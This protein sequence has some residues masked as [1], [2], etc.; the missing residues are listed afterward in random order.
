MITS[1]D[2]ERLKLVRKLADRKH[3][4]RERL[5]AAEG[6]D[7]VEAAAAAGWEPEFVLRA[8]EDVEPELLDAV[9]ALGSG[10]R[11][12][13]VYRQRWAGPADPAPAI[14]LH[15]VG[16]PANVGTIVRSAHALAGGCVVIGPGTRRPVLAEGGAGEHGLGLRAAA[17]PRR[18]SRR[19]PSRGAAL[20]AH[21]G[22]HGL[23][24][25][26]RRDGLP[27]RRARRPARR[28][29]RGVRVAVDDPAAPGRPGEPR[30]GR[31]GGDRSPAAIVGAARGRSRRTVSTIDRIESLRAEAS[32]AIA[33]AGDGAALEELRVRYLGRKSELTAI[34]RGIAELDPAERGAGRQGRERG[35]RR[36]SRRELEARVV[37]ARVA[38]ALARSL[39]EDCDRHH[40]ARD[41]ARR[42]RPPAPAD[43]DA[44]RDRGHLRRPRLPGDGG[45]GDRARLLQLHRPQPPARPPGAADPGQLLRRPG[46]AAR[47]A[48]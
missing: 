13:G 26:R 48:S 19:R 8:G 30:R 15:G 1:T 36:R 10:T 41:R 32:A 31:G 28:G 37:G 47:R 6:E 14:Y 39:A 2:N 23:D 38:S 33:A 20:V 35:P 21:G 7:L 4:D 24:A 22:D 45:A 27:R 5:F 12:I 25:P 34:L 17:R 40:A 9:S 42:A 11:V 46:D 16:D 29:A 44:A 18:R 43:A 3:R